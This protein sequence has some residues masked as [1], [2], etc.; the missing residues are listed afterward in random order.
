VWGGPLG[1]P[2]S[3]R[4]CNRLNMSKL[5]ALLLAGYLSNGSRIAHPSFKGCSSSLYLS[6][7]TF[8]EW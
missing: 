7:L 6:C 5:R 8:A 1:K 2:H 3:R 4:T